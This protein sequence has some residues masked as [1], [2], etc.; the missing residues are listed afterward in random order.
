[1]EPEES[2]KK[3]VG[4]IQVQ[5]GRVSTKKKKGKSWKTAK[6]KNNQTCTEHRGKN[7]GKEPRVS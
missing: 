2:S 4:I 1:M 3:A 6:E 5:S 7:G